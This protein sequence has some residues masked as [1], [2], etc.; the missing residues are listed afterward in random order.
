MSGPSLVN[1]ML[2][3]WLSFAPWL[4][5]FHSGTAASISV[6]VGLTVILLALFSV[7]AP[8]YRAFAL[9][10]ALLGAS[11]FLAPWVLGYANE[12]AAMWNSVL[13]GGFVLLFALGR[14]AVRVPAGF[15]EDQRME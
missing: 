15:G 14:A 5:P 3:T 4:L 13:V 8:T 1:V 6:L 10:N 11:L 9:L 12:P 7:A 2:G